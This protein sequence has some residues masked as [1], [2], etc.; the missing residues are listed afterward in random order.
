MRKLLT[1][2][3]I[4][5]V[6]TDHSSASHL[7]GGEITWKCIKSGSDAGKYRFTVIV[8]RDCQGVPINTTMSLTAHNV[9]GLNS[10]PLSYVGA[11]DLSPACDAIDGPNSPFSCNGTNIGNAG[12]GNGAVEEHV[13]QSEAIFI[14]GTPDAN[15][16]HFTWGACCRNVN[17]SNLQNVAAN[18][19]GFLL[20]AVMYSYTDSLGTVFPNGNTCFDSSPKF[21]ETPRTILEVDNGYDP[22]AFSNGF[23]YSHNAF[24]EERD[25]LSYDWL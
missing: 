3:L 8:Y 21:Y 7:M 15:G 10:I 20:R 4:L 11:T 1:I 24:D 23:T 12:N 5:F 17:I 9:P 16:W 2:L 25:S 18:T 22:L 14:P 13:Y 6:F 19:T